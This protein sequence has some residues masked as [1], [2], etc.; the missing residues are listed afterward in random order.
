MHRRRWLARC[1]VLL[2]ALTSAA[3]MA[4]AAQLTSVGSDTLGELMQALAQAYAQ[5]QPQLRFQIQTPGSAAALPALAEGRAD[6]GPMSRSMN[7]AEE[8]AYRARRG[9]SP[10]QVQIGFDAVAVFVHPDNPLSQLSLAQLAQIWADGGSCAG[11]P[12][13]RWDQLDVN[14]V[15][16]QAL[17]RLGRNTSS[18]TYEFFQNAAFCGGSYRADV[19][20]FPGAGA[21][22]AA[23]A[24]HPRAI[25][26]ASLAHANGLVRL[27]ALQPAHDEAAVL[28]DAASVISGRY[29]LARPL[30]LYFNH[31]ADGRADPA[32]AAFLRYVL[33]PAGQDL[34]RRQGLFGLSP[35]HANEQLRQ[36]Q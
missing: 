29:P 18:G 34:V 10:G 24:Q 5:E 1:V 6:L 9:S 25:G 26:Y 12:L 21:V 3:T 14:T 19:V 23:V 31:G 36:L 8:A 16:P 11:T 33:G 30:Y 22:V 17:L 15:Q 28:P 2:L 4:T 13:L 27:V 7:P 32:T 35:Q 20:Q